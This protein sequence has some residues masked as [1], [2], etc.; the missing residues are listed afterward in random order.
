M[1]NVLVTIYDSAG[2]PKADAVPTFSAI[3]STTGGVLPNPVI[4]NLGNGNYG[5]QLDVNAGYLISTGANPSYATGGIGNGAWFVLYDSAGQPKAD[6]APSVQL[7]SWSGG[8]LGAPSIANCGSGLYWFNYE[9]EAIFKITTGCY[10]AYIDGEIEI[11]VTTTTGFVPPTPTASPIITILPSNVKF[12]AQIDAAT[13]EWV[14][15]ALGYTTACDTEAA[16]R[17]RVWLRLNTMRSEL[18]FDLDVGHPW[19]EWCNELPPRINNI[20]DSIVDEIGGVEG[21]RTV[22]ADVVFENR[23]L[24]ATII[25]NGNVVVTFGA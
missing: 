24:T 18:S 4:S 5:F 22:T 7:Y 21:V 17:Q 3:R 8:S 16:L 25:V 23:Q 6:A 14:Y 11:P 12:D 13:G 19:I 10:P 20:R 1:S 9:S 2:L 15:D